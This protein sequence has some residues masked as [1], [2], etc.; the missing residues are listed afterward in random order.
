[1]IIYKTLDAVIYN[2]NSLLAQLLYAK[3]LHK[4]IDIKES[5]GNNNCSLIFLYRWPSQNC[6]DFE[7]FLNNL[8]LYLDQDYKK[9][10]F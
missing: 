3:C 10:T 8:E 1:M 9:N 6:Y 5:I 2:E 7:T 4:S